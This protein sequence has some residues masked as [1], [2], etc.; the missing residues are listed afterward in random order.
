VWAEGEDD[1]AM[2]T[3]VVD[4]RESDPEHPDA[5]RCL[6]A[7]YRELDERFEDGFDPSAGEAVG[8][9][10]M[11][12]PRGRLL[13]ACVDGTP[14]GCGAII[15]HPDGTAEVK[16]LWVDRS[17]RGLG[18]G[19]RLLRALEVIAAERGCGA[20]RLDS[21]RS[22]TEAIT[23]YRGAGYREVPAFNANPYADFWFEKPLG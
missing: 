15:F 9:D 18:T 4:I 1:R 12:L 22:L 10:E 6:E 8:P 2:S 5:Q 21:N 19:R 3:E 20:V 13:L 14:V 7:Y 17:S 23:L 16:R 11:R